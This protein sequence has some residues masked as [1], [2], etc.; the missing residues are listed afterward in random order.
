MNEA[1]S[2]RAARQLHEQGIRAAALEG[3]FTAW[4]EQYAVEPTGSPAAV[5]P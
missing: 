5:T 4:R 3:G 1:T 2:A